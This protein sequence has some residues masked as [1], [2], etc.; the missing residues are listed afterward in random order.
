MFAQRSHSTSHH[1]RLR[2]RFPFCLCV[3]YVSSQF[4]HKSRK[5]LFTGPGLSRCNSFL[6]HFLGLTYFVDRK[7]FYYTFRVSRDGANGYILGYFGNCICD[8]YSAA[9]VTIPILQWWINSDGYFLFKSLSV[10]LL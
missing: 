10:C 7:R 4:H 6:L 8:A 3:I 9:Y 5:L 1:F 2:N